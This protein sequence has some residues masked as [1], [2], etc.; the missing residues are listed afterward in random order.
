[1]IRHVVAFRLSAPDAR[2]RKVDLAGMRERLE[3]LGRSVA[4][5]FD[6]RVHGDLGLVDSHW[7]AVLVSDHPDNAALEAYQAHPE[8]VAAVEWV[9][10]VVADR[11]V[12]DFEIDR[13]DR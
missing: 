8:H 9:N 12:V 6:L 10:T 7:H 11:A 1:V 13:D 4:G 5:V 3:P 2:Q